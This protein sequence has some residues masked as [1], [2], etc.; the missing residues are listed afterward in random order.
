MIVDFSFRKMQH[1]IVQVQKEKNCQLQ[2]LY[3]VKLSFRHEGEIK[4]ISDK[5]KLREF[6]YSSSSLKRWMKEILL[7]ERK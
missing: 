1:N 4:T 2:T 7:T 6:V 5:G 3:L